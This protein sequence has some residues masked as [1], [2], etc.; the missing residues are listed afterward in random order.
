MKKIIGI[1]GTITMI[2]TPVT[3][4]I[5]CNQQER[6]YVPTRNT[7]MEADISQFLSQFT[8]QAFNDEGDY[9]VKHDNDDLIFTTF[10]KEKEAHT[11]APIINYDFNNSEAVSAFELPKQNILF[12]TYLVAMPS[13]LPPPEQLYR[14]FQLFSLIR[15]TTAYSYTKGETTMQEITIDGEHLTTK[16]YYLTINLNSNVFWNYEINKDLLSYLI[17]YIQTNPS[18][19][20]SQNMTDEAIITRWL[21]AVYTDSNNFKISNIKTIKNISALTA[22]LTDKLNFQFNNLDTKQI[23]KQGEFNFNVSDQKNNY[24]WQLN[25]LKYE[26]R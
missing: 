8:L 14:D 3:T 4:V 22:Y 1:L 6:H 2:V 25:Q 17:N 11:L 16:I 23:G 12:K 18:F 5:S 13:K 9:W 20:F 21:T 24:R 26:I 7:D 10:N 15:N 19:I